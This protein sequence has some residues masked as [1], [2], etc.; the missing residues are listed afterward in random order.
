MAHRFYQLLEVIFRNHIETLVELNHNIFSMLCNSLLDGLYN[1]DKNLSSLAAS[2]IDELATYQFLQV[3]RKKKDSSFVKLEVLLNENAETLRSMMTSIFILI[4]FEGATN[5]W[6]F[7]RPLF[8]LILIQEAQFSDFAQQLI[9]SQPAQHQQEVRE[10][11][12]RLM[13]DVRPVLEN[14]NRDKFTQNL[15]YFS[16]SMKKILVR[17]SGM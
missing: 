4:L 2:A 6:S 15:V 10:G 9:N 8:S 3:K 7:S 12:A 1:L 5:L 17:P 13:E 11:F 16:S 14:R